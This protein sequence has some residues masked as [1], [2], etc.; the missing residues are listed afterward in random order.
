MIKNNRVVIK[1][2]LILLVVGS[3]LGVIG[4]IYSYFSLEVEGQS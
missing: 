1:I 4:F 2:I 3:V